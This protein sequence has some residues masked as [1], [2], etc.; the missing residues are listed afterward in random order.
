MVKLSLKVK[1]AC[2]IRT[3]GFRIEPTPLRR[4]PVSSCGMYAL[5]KGNKNQVGGHPP[6]YAGSFNPLK[7]YGGLLFLLEV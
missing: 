4:E 1:N 6:A 5:H 3:D 2:C 7:R